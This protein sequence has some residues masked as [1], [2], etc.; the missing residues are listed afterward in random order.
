MTIETAAARPRVPLDAPPS[1]LPP[2]P[3]NKKLQKR[4][5]LHPPIPNIHS[6]RSPQIVYVSARTPFISAVKR[7]RKILDVQESALW[8]GGGGLDDAA[9]EQAKRVKGYRNKQRQRNKKRG[10][11]GGASSAMGRTGAADGGRGAQLGEGVLLKATGKAIDKCLS[12]GMYFMK[13][14]TVSVRIGTGSVDVVDDVVD[15]P[16][17]SAVKKLANKERLNI[18]TPD[19]TTTAPS[20]NTSNKNKKRKSEEIEDFR[21][22]TA[23]SNPLSPTGKRPKT[24]AENDTYMDGQ[25]QQH[26]TEDTSLVSISSP[27]VLPTSDPS[28]L[29][30]SMSDPDTNNEADDVED[31]EAGDDEDDCDYMRT[32]KTSMVEIKITLVRP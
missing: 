19:T 32:R 30:V 10:G 25:D 7:I 20:N 2:L 18:E 11:R 4:P 21:H 23:S 1:K 12:L 8:L 27:A 17:A 6:K 13:D 5:L 16:G 29:D 9:E 22:T 3:P 31:D 15:R 26:P 14:T 28:L 24:D